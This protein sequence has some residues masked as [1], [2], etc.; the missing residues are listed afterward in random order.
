MDTP[1]RIGVEFFS[2]QDDQRAKDA[3]LKEAISSPTGPETQQVVALSSPQAELQ[4][5]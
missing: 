3:C 2:R 4:S 5:L 1:T